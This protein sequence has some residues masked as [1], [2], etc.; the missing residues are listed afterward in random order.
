AGGG[1]GE[2]GGGAARRRA[3]PMNWG[4]WAFAAALVLLMVFTL[5]PFYWAIVA[6]FTSDAALFRDPS[7]IPSHLIFDHYRAL[8]TDRDFITPIRN[9]LVVAGTTTLFCLV[10]GTLAAYALAR[11]E[12]R[13]KAPI[14]AFILAVTMFPQISIVSPLYLLLRSLHLIDTYPGLI[15][16]YM[17]FAM[18][19]T[20]WVLTGS[21]RQIPKDLEEAAHVDGASRLQSFLRIL[22]PLAVPSLATTGI[23]TF[24]YCWNEFLFAL[25]FTLG[26]ERQTVP[27][28]IA[29][30]RGQYQVPWGEILA[31]AVVATAPVAGLV[32]V[33][34]RRI[35]QGLTAGAVKG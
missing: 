29:L 4:N 2:A 11:I 18:P 15:M 27:V 3:R 31:A 25:S 34:Q 5:F 33:F 28:A 16:P 20:V 32:L 1:R 13:G 21:I 10:V 7:L 14:M 23:L 17:T 26:P 19:L 12:F 6:S 30:F 24:I 22:L 35:V 8:F 9:S